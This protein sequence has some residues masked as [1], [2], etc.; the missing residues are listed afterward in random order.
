MWWSR[1]FGISLRNTSL[2]TGSDPVPLRQAQELLTLELP[3]DEWVMI[4]VETEKEERREKKWKK[5]SLLALKGL[6]QKSFTSPKAFRARWKTEKGRK[7]LI[8]FSVP[9]RLTSY[10][11]SWQLCGGKINCRRETGLPWPE[12]R[13]NQAR[14]GETHTESDR[15]VPPSSEIPATSDSM[16]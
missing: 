15:Q 16:W 4:V 10:A 9:A 7:L 12:S 13:T 6:Q 1:P 14:K 2:D 11:I 5:L 3:V 8:K